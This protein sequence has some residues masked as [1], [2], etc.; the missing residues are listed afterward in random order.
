[1]GIVSIDVRDFWPSRNFSDWK[2]AR[3]IASRN[4]RFLKNSP[5]PN[6][7]PSSH[8]VYNALRVQIFP[9]KNTCYSEGGKLS[10]WIYLHF[11]V[12][13]STLLPLKSPSP[14]TPKLW[15]NSHI[16]LVWGWPRGVWCIEGEMVPTT[17]G[18]ISSCAYECVYP[19]FPMHLS[20]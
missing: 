7:V 14:Q 2:W 12:S 15:V 16:G 4:Y 1:M 17:S 20:I 11:L 13:P 9:I 19:S 5:S 3:K 6:H 8:K 10:N 18:I